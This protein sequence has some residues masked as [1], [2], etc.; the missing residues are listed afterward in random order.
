[1]ASDLIRTRRAFAVASVLT[2]LAV[3]MGSVVCATESG[4]ACPTWPGC[5]PDRITPEV[6]LNPLV[7]FTH[8]VVAILSAP[9][10]LYAALRARRLPTSE[11]FVRMAPWLALAGAL[12]AGVFGMLTVLVGIPLWAGM[13]DMFCAL[14]AMVLMTWAWR[15]V[16]ALSGGRAWRI[17][18]SRP[19][20]LAVAALGVLVVVHLLGLVVAGSG[21]Y[22]RCISWPVCQVVESDGYDAVQVLRIGLAGL[23]LALAIVAGVLAIRDTSRRAVSLALLIALAAEVGLTLVLRSTHL[24]NALGAATSASAVLILWLLAVL[25]V[26]QD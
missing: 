19:A 9:S 15:A 24:T 11:R 10:V 26:D 4:A 2:L 14:A 12:A 13:L 20:Q 17:G 22:T 3:V 16:A 6:E 21:S 5:Y 25:S 23:A 7:E 8:R 1:M 18:G